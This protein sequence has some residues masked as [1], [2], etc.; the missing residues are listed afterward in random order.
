M[1]AGDRYIVPQRFLSSST[2]AEGGASQICRA[3]PLA[4]PPGRQRPG[5]G[6]DEALKRPSPPWQLVFPNGYQWEEGASS[7]LRNLSQAV[8][9]FNKLFRQ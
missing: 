2:N 5:S 7:A 3:G 1:G 9:R 6:K 8:L 4:F